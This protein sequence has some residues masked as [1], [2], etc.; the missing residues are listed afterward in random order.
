ML[1]W[2]PVSAGA[3]TKLKFFKAFLGNPLQVGAVLPS[4][5]RLAQE[6][7]DPIDFETAKVIVEFGPGTGAFT[8]VIQR[9]LKPDTK[10]LALELNPSMADGIEARFP[11]VDLIRDSAENLLEHLEARGIDKVD[12][13]VSGLP[14]A[15]FPSDLQIRILEAA[16]I[17]LA[18]GGQFLSFT[19]YHSIP[20]PTANRYF[21]RLRRIFS[22]VERV[23][24]LRNI[25]PAFV[26]RAR[27]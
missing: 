4:G 15:F 14:F 12:A 20:L 21:A 18:P 13:I 1:G 5:E 25:P 22:E 6:I 19:Y 9:R 26:L 23:P 16:C 11:K 17:A 24:V 27:R 8:Q 7:T 2:A 3:P 10:F